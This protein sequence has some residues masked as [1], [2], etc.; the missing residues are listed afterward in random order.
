MSKTLITAESETAEQM[1]GEHWGKR[2][3]EIRESRNIGVEA[4]AAELRLETKLVQQI[5]NEELEQLPEAPFVKG[6]LRNYARM[7]NVD[8][9]PFLAAYSLVCGADAPG[10]T[11]VSRVRE[12]TSKSVAP[13]STTWIIVAVLVISVLVWWWSQILTFKKSTEETVVPAPTSEQQSAP[14]AVTEGSNGEAVIE[15]A[16]PE[17]PQSPQQ[18]PAATTGAA[19]ATNGTAATTATTAA[20]PKPNTI[21]LKFSGESWVEISDVSGARLLMDM[22]KAN[23]SRTVTGAAPFK[24]LLG[25]SPAVA[26]E[27]NGAPYDHSAYNKKGIARFTLGAAAE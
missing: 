18:Q 23:D 7:L 27:Y 19:S 24:V 1:P 14:V 17:Q 13:R 22:I 4:V 15:L 11:N 12:L 3:R 10:L 5:E 6:Y 21:T 2:L 8:A 9:A 16:L 20:A 26:I 25:N